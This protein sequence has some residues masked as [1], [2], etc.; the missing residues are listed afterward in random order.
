M[1][2][3]GR[4]EV[5]NRYEVLS[6]L[7]EKDASLEQIAEATKKGLDEVKGALKKLAFEGSVIPLL[8]GTYR[9]KE[10]DVFLG[11]VKVR[12]RDHAYVTLLSKEGKDVRISGEDALSVLKGDE[13]FLKLDEK[14]E[15]NGSGS[16]IRI[17]RPREFVEGMVVFSEDGLVLD[18]LGQ[19]ESELVFRILLS[20][21]KVDEGDLVRAE[22]VRR[23]SFSLDVT[24]SKRLA[25]PGDK[26]YDLTKAALEKGASFT[27]P[28]DV[29]KEAS[30]FGEDLSFGDRSDRR[31]LRGEVVVT[32]DGQTTKDFDDGLS[33][34]RVPSGYEV[35]V[36][37][38]DVASFVEEASPLDEEARL[39]A[40]SLYFP[41]ME[42][43]MLPPSL[44]DGR[45]SLNEGEDRLSITCLLRLDPE[46]R[47]L[48]SELF[49]S[50]VRSRARLTYDA[51]D[52]FLQG[53]EKSIP[54]S[55]APAVLLLLECA[56][57]VQKRRKEEGLLTFGRNY[58]EFSLDEAGFPSSVRLRRESE[59]ENLVEVFMILAN[60]EVGRKLIEKKVPALFRT[61]AEPDAEKMEKIKEFLA[62]FEI[63]PALFPS[64]CSSNSLAK[65]FEGL[66][67]WA[68]A[69]GKLC[70]LKVMN[71]VSYSRAPG[72]HFA[73]NC[74]GYVYFTSPIRRYP[75]LLTHRLIHEFLFDENEADKESVGAYLD[76]L[77]SLLAQEEKT[78]K[79]IMNRAHDMACER[80]MSK[81]L[82]EICDGEVRNFVGGGI[83]VQLS[84]GITGLLPYD[85]I[86]GDSYRPE[87]LSFSVIG[88]DEGREIVLG[89]VL[90]VAA[91]ETDPE[92]FSVLLAT[93]ED[94]KASG[95]RNSEDLLAVLKGEGVE[96]K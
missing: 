40:T 5:M 43:S 85:R 17:V 10:K 82:G 35:G 45:C 34:R 96:V 33:I 59:A 54:P 6:V 16:L 14:Y 21:L 92:T 46:G 29:E 36:H 91:V 24:P 20:S 57:K 3:T 81:H 69:I 62:R 1:E 53:E 93:E 41:E 18:A 74:T 64:T 70:L 13:V 15:Y 12:F 60:Q 63:D 80:Y 27:Y 71:P 78:A 95:K 50:K 79:W 44:A 23:G 38:A 94:L 65:Y 66:P 61:E 87:R 42:V 83:K 8:D 67:A 22:V 86:D 89:D 55:V 30:G 31:D 32:V 76:T 84:N 73:L 49:P 90:Q 26:F 11:Y 4:E 39:R 28:F 88:R 68:S 47:L 2:N 25:K 77:P 75:D 51:V 9:A 58:P 19:R 72:K 48:S 37:I 52:L 56:K 7:K